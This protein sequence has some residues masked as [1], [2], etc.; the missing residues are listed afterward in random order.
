MATASANTSALALGLDVAITPAA[1]RPC[2]SAGCRLHRILTA[3]ARY[4]CTGSAPTGR[5]HA[6]RIHFRLSRR[7]PD[8]AQDRADLDRARHCRSRLLTHWSACN[9]GAAVVAQARDRHRRSVL[10]LHPAGGALRAHRPDGDGRGLSLRHSRHRGADRV[11]RRRP[12]PAGASCRYGRRRSSS[13]SRRISCCTGST[14]LYHGA[15][16]VE[17]PRRPSLLR[18]ARLDF[19]GALPSGQ[20][21]PRHRAGRRRA[22]ARRHF[23]ERDAV[24]RAFHDR[25]FGLR[26]CQSELDARAVQIRAGQPG[27]SPL[28]PHRGRSRRQQ[29]FRRHVS[30]CWI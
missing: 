7:R 26:A 13:W 24:G 3:L 29:E 1:G 14:A 22:A 11:L 9:P 12:R 16:D 10:V 21:L 6:R 25:A 19:G 30:R 15:A 20:H 17:V 28:A 2:R 5:Q 4:R 27:V 8:H 18:R 23:A